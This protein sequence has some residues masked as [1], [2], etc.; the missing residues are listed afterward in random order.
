MKDRFFIVSREITD[1]PTKLTPPVRA[2][3]DPRRRYWS[4]IAYLYGSESTPFLPQSRQEEMTVRNLVQI[5]YGVPGI[6]LYSLVLWALISLRKQLSRSFLVIYCLLIFTNIITWL[7]AWL[8][9]K[10]NT[11]Q[12]AF[13]SY[14]EW[15]STQPFLINTC[16]FLVSNFNYVQN[17]YL[18]FLTFD[19]YAAIVSVTRN[20]KWWDNYHKWIILVTHV[21][22]LGAHMAIRL[23]MDISLKV[24]PLTGHYTITRPDSENSRN[25][26][27][28]NVRLAFGITIFVICSMLNVLSLLRLRVLK[29]TKTKTIQ[30]SFFAISMCIFATQSANV[31]VSVLIAV[32]NTFQIA[33]GLAFAYEAVSYFSDLFSIGPA[34]YTIILPGLIR[35]FLVQKILKVLRMTKTDSQPPSLTICYGLP[36]IIIL[37]PLVLWALTALRKQLSRSFLLVY[38]L[39]IF[40]NIITWLNAWLYLKLKAEKPFFSYYEWMSHLPFLIN[41]CNFL[42]SHFNY[43]QNLYLLFLT[44]DR[45]AAIASIT[46]NL[47]WWKNYY[48]W[49]IVMTHAV[50]L[51]A[52]MAIRLPMS[53]SL[54]VNPSTGNFEMIRPDSE[55]SRNALDAN[56][57]LGFGI[58]IFVICFILNLRSLLTVWKMKNTKTR[59]IQ[60]T[61]LAITLCIFITQACNVAISVII[62]ILNSFKSSGLD[63]AYEAVSYFSDF[64]SIGPALYTIILPGLVRQF[65]HRKIRMVLRMS[66]IDSQPPS[67]TNVHA[68]RPDS[69]AIQTITT[70]RN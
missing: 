32:F 13:Y 33:G 37:Y 39:L 24:N 30:W 48:K 66:P 34:L 59:T 36:C 55:N 38:Y 65:L 15:M 42:V 61:F 27:D 53:I 1:I 50:V 26:L 25:A 46:R 47:K 67:L 22:V 54:Q 3:T 14:Y 40:S 62:A 21:I 51:G 35:Q 19:R 28:A 41:T 57:R 43:V 69:N 52:H 29:K 44:V 16:N 17:L 68:Y 10:L 7:N 49:I 23:P 63:F 45:Y 58:S 70:S 4:N 2:R 20:M 31:A 6:S 9:L 8:Y 11:E 56:V 12:P 64:F 60:R 5:C 18:L